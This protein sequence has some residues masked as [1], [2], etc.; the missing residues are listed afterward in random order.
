MPAP[1]RDLTGC[2]A[3][4]ARAALTSDVPRS[5]PSRAVYA[6]SPLKRLR[7]PDC[8]VGIAAQRLGGHRPRT[9]P[10]REHAPPAD[11]P[12]P[13]DRH[14]REKLRA[15]GVLPPDPVL[16]EHV[17]CH[18]DG[19]FPQFDARADDRQLRA[20]LRN[21]PAQKV[22]VSGPGIAPGDLLKLEQFARVAQG[23]ESLSNQGTSCWSSSCGTGTSPATRPGQR[24]GWWDNKQP[25][26]LR[27]ALRL[28]RRSRRETRAGGRGHDHRPRPQNVSPTRSFII[29]GLHN[30]AKSAPWP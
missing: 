10:V 19:P 4:A 3:G 7:V 2:S 21:R 27:G 11:A 16:P 25:W 5:T 18:V 17:G 20:G 26:F 14:R 23:E 29:E 1:G 28:P 24:D 13:H 8:P 6:I 30:L 9:E 22:G 15:R 12:R